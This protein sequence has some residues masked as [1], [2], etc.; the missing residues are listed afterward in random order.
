MVAGPSEL[1]GAEIVTFA[2]RYDPRPYHLS[3]IAARESH[4]GGL[5]ASGINTMALWNNLRFEAEAGLD[6]IAGVGLDEVRFHHPVRPGDRLSLRVEC[7]AKQPSRGK[8]DRGVLSFQHEL[9]NQNGEL[10][11]SLRMQMLA[12]R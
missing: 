9:S 1:P 7:L 3:E 4:F 12:A 2:E 8:S 11:M 6:Q 5:V 10:V